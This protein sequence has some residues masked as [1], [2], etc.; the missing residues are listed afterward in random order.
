[1]NN[2]TALLQWIVRRN[3]PCDDAP[4]LFGKGLPCTDYGLSQKISGSLI[5]F[6]KLFGWR[7]SG[8]HR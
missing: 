8:L 6:I 3:R 2:A 1:M 4:A 7:L 5:F